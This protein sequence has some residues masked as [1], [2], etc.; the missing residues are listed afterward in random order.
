MV[1]NPV[2]DIDFFLFGFIVFFFQNMIIKKSSL[3]LTYLSVILFKLSFLSFYR[4]A[5][6]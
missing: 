2:K 6:L 1:R 3:L 5:Y 4:S